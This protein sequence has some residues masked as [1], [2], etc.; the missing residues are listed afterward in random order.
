VKLGEAHV[1]CAM[2][3]SPSPIQP[4][5]EITATDALE[6]V[7]SQ[8]TLAL[9]LYDPQLNGP[10]LYLI[11]LDATDGPRWVQLGAGFSEPAFS[12]DG[13]RLAVRSSLPGQEGLVIIDEAG[14]LVTV[15]P[16]TTQAARP[17]WSRDGQRIAFVVTG[18]EP[19]SHR[20]YAVQADGQSDPEE[21]VSGWSPTW[22]PEGWL[23]YTGCDDEACGIHVLSPGAETPIR[24]TSSGQD[25]GLNWSPDGQ[26]L[27][28]MSDHD[29]DWEVHI[30]TREGWVRQLTVNEA[31]DGL[32][33]WSPGGGELLFVS[34]RDGSWGLY[35]MRADGGDPTAPPEAVKL[36]DL[37]TDYNGRWGQAQIAWAP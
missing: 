9:T 4:S 29:G 8:G 15:L 14:Q 7:M 25:I 22:G 17:S 5:N 23:A 24:I 32:P 35:L 19:T 3:S 31:R 6:S 34:D 16:G 2:A 11:H 1:R 26:R 21:L 20:I 33:V 13:N 18:D 10:A 12:P 28:Y 37:S 30:T 27:A 36:F